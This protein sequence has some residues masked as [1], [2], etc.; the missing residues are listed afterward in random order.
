MSEGYLYCEVAGDRVDRLT[1]RR[2]DRPGALVEVT[3]NG[4]IINVEPAALLLA[5]KTVTEKE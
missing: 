3:L 4:A 1:F 5:V 2:A